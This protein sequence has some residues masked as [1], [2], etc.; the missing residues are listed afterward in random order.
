[1]VKVYNKQTSYIIVGNKY[2]APF[3]SETFKSRNAIIR[4]LERN[5]VVRVTEVAP[6]NVNPVSPELF[7]Y[8]LKKDEREVPVVE[9]I[10]ENVEKQQQQ[11]QEEISEKEVIEQEEI[12]EEVV[13]NSEESEIITEEQPK[14]TT[15]KRRNSKKKGE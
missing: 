3:K 10:V 5:G 9:D 4:S 12:V 6:I 15:R 7:D 11:Q 14:P 1:M 8:E 2:I 13:E